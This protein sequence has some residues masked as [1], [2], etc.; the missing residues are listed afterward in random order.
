ML[1]Q[2]ATRAVGWSRFNP[3]LPESLSSRIPLRQLYPIELEFEWITAGI[4]RR[5]A[6]NQNVIGSPGLSTGGTFHEKG[7]TVREKR[8]A[9]Q[10]IGRARMRP[11]DPL[12]AD[13]EPY[14]FS[15]D[16][17]S[18]VDHEDVRALTARG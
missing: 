9:A 1:S 5:G 16:L 7:A 15:G 4:H 3:S 12:A 13:D 2:G 8:L 11:L 14:G 6:K 18:Q 17:W 10:N